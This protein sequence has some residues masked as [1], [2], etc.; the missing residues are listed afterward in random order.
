M[1]PPNITARSS[2]VI[3][4]EK[5]EQGGGLDPFIGGENHNPITKPNTNILSSVKIAILILHILNIMLAMAC[6]L[7]VSNV[8]VY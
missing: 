3:V 8:H 5:L 2:S 7:Y 1:L 4:I 6:T